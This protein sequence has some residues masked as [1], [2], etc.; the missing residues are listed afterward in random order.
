MRD[1]LSDCLACE[2]NLKLTYYLA[3]HKFDQAFLLAD[4]L[5]A[6]KLV[7]ETVPNTTY[8]KLL[9]PFFEKGQ[10]EKATNWHHK[11]LFFIYGVPLYLE[12]Q[13]NHLMYL[14][15]TDL[16]EAKLF[17][18]DHVQLSH[19]SDNLYAKFHFYLASLVLAV[20]AK[21]Q[22]VVMEMDTDFFIDS[23]CNIGHAFDKRNQND[24]YR[25]Y[26]LSFLE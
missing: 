1:S 20:E 14:T 10:T 15:R 4:E 2:T 3:H 23:V 25:Q 8:A 16:N 18:D 12:E 24:Y 7:C 21:K 5:V 17:F 26:V 6:T 9:I 11:G 22:G 19:E 13:A